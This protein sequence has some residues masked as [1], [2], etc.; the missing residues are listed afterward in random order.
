MK[1][2]VV[3]TRR[4]D[5]LAECWTQ[6]PDRADVATASDRIDWQLQRDPLHT[7]EERD[8]GSRILIEPP[9][10]VLFTVSEDDC[11]VSVYDA[12]RWTDPTPTN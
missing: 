10:A 4:G 8:G 2:T 3:A 7:G 12:W 6:S 9:L 11:L 5:Y 1:W